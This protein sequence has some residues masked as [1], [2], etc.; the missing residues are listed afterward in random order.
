[1]TTGEKKNAT[2]NCINNFDLQSPGTW[3]IKLTMTDANNQTSTA[4]QQIFVKK[5]DNNNALIK[6]FDKEKNQCKTT[7]STTLFPNP[8]QTVYDFG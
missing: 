5:P 6:I 1:M 7:D 2:G 3:S 8:E 4:Y